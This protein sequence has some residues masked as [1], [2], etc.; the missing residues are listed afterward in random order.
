MLPFLSPHARWMSRGTALTAASHTDTKDD[1]SVELQPIV[2]TADTMARQTI[3]GAYEREDEPLLSSRNATAIPA[4]VNAIEDLKY[5]PSKR[6][7]LVAYL[8]FLILGVRYTY[9]NHE[10]KLMFYAQATVLLP[11]C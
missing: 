10:C 7:K 11:W 6:E 8:C 4:N 1:D 9:M 2:D 3:T 5:T